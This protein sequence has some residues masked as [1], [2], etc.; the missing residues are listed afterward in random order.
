MKKILAKKKEKAGEKPKA[1]AG[2]AA[3]KSKPK[4]KEVESRVSEDLTGTDGTKGGKSGTAAIGPGDCD[5]AGPGDGSEAADPDEDL[6]DG[7]G[8]SATKVGGA[9]QKV[10]DGT[11]GSGKSALGPGDC[12]VIGPSGASE[13]R[14]L[15]ESKAEE[16]DL[17]RIMTR[18]RTNPFSQL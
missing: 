11:K 4:E 9:D 18:H 13:S 6:E 14:K 16:H 8:D 3:D 15:K 5:M 2:T 10:K 12:K 7:T 1:A 17:L